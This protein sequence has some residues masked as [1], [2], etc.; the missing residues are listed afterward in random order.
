MLPPAGHMQAVPVQAGRFQLCRGAEVE[1]EPT[2]LPSPGQSK[3]GGA[4]QCE[5]PCPSA[6]ISLSL[7]ACPFLPYKFLDLKSES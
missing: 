2:L 5:E 6:Q 3:H 1:K 7:P 4:G